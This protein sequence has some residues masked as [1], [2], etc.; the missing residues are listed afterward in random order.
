MAVFKLFDNSAFGSDDIALC[1]FRNWSN[2][3]ALQ[4]G[5]R[6]LEYCYLPGLQA[7]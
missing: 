2:L 4:E 7:C 6:P 5:R 1:P 3:V